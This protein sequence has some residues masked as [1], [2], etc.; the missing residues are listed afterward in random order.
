M[1]GMVSDGLSFHHDRRRTVEEEKSTPPPARG[2]QFQTTTPSPII[3][4]GAA[5]SAHFCAHSVCTVDVASVDI[6][7][8]LRVLLFC[9]GKK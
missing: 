4:V 2:F 7:L 1:R 9:L 6:T 5:T 8:G 3:T